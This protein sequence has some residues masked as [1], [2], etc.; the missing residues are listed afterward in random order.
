MS[1]TPVDRIAEILKDAGYV[2]LPTPLEIRGLRFEIQSAFV[3]A[4][5][6]PDLIIVADTAFEDEKR[7]LRKLEGIARALDLAGSRRPL[8][9]I[10]AG[11]RP[12]SPVIGA[13]VRVCRVLPVGPTGGTDFETRLINWLAVLLPLVLPAPDQGVA[14]PFA[15]LAGHLDGLDADVVD[16]IDVATEGKDPVRDQLI[17]LVA[18]PAAGVEAD[19]Q[20]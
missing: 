5:P 6:S 16:L 14:D 17:E 1:G 7:I 8:T 10:L 2:A 3:G 4:S 15:E 19:L 20:P 12:T 18:A 13:M 11:P 9:A